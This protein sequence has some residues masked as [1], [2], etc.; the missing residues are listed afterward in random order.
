MLFPDSLMPDIYSIF[1]TYQF[2]Y[3]SGYRRPV[4]IVGNKVDLLPADGS[5]YLKRIEECLISAV[6]KTELG[7]ANIKHTALVS[8]HTGYGVERLITKIQNSWGVKGK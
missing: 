6:N 5:N 1:Y 3:F 7:R 2:L 4:V 8:A